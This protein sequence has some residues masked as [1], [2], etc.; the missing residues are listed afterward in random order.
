MDY[1]AALNYKKTFGTSTFDGVKNADVII[2]NVSEDSTS[3]VNEL[4]KADKKSSD[5]Y[6]G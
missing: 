5:D 6:R 3:A 1:A 4:L 2:E